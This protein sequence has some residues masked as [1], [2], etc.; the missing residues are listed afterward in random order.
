MMEK[1][2]KSKEISNIRMLDEASFCHWHMHIKIHLRF[3]DLIDMCKK[4]V[5]SDASTTIFNKW[6]RASYEAINLIT[7][8]LTERVFCEVV[9]VEPLRKQTNSGQ[10]SKI[11]ILQKGDLTEAKYGWTGRETSMMATFKATL[12]YAGK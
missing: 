3:N 5:P 9:N 8:R 11:N 1:A 4:Y 7:T 2:L 12:T 10:R 6:S